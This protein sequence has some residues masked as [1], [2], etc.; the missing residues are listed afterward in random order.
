MYCFTG[1][2]PYC[3]FSPKQTKQLLCND[4]LQLTCIASYSANWTYVVP[5]IR[6]SND[7]SSAGLQGLMETTIAGNVVT[8]TSTLNVTW[9]VDG[10]GVMPIYS[11]STTFSLIDGL[12]SEFITKPPN[13]NYS[14]KPFTSPSDV[15]CK[16][17]LRLV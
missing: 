16:S 6:W 3:Y 5:N 1:Q 8:A 12:S 17:L 11:C 9:P 14:C 7:A 15:P 10:A 2:N 13:Y 4:T